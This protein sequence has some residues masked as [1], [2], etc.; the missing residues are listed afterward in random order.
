MGLQIVTYKAY[1]LAFNYVKWRTCF[2]E[3]DK[4]TRH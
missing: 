1:R 3:P 2:Y 4:T